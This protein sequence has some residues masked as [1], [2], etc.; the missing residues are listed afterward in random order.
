MGGEQRF[1]ISLTEGNNFAPSQCPLHLSPS[2]HTSK[3]NGKRNLGRR[4]FQSPLM[5]QK[6]LHPLSPG[7]APDAGSPETSGRKHGSDEFQG[8]SAWPGLRSDAQ[9]RKSARPG[10]L[11]RKDRVSR[12]PPID[13]GGNGNGKR[14][15][16]AGWLRPERPPVPMAQIVSH[17][18]LGQYLQ[19]S[20][21]EGAI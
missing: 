15:F 21:G 7:I 9:C 14:S 6:P 12:F 19:G 10:H 13:P 16:F 20:L 17:L 1:L 18:N 3:E 8:V 2:G 11:I 5:P 4:M